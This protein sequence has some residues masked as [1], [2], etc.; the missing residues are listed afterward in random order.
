MAAE[1]ILGLDLEEWWNLIKIV[2]GVLLV[3]TVLDIVGLFVHEGAHIFVALAL[4]C[5]V[6]S[7]ELV[8]FSSSGFVGGEVWIR[9]GS[10]LVPIAFAGGFAEGLYFL[11]VRKYIKSQGLWI[12]TLSCWV[13]ALAEICWVYSPVEFPLAMPLIEATRLLSFAALYLSLLWPRLDELFYSLDYQQ[14]SVDLS[15]WVPSEYRRA[16]R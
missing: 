15:V 7:I 2:F 16:R 14:A 11:V 1:A 6:T 5:E 4:G 12:A 13:Y 10:Y 8:I 3:T 9:L